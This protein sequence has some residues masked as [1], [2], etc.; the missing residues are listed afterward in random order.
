MSVD[1]HKQENNVCVIAFG[2]NNEMNSWPPPTNQIE[3]NC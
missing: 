2:Q 3:L 1:D